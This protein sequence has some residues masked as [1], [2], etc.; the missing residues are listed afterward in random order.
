ML[1]WEFMNL[2]IDMFL[3]KEIEDYI[4]LYFNYNSVNDNLFES[5]VD[6][7]STLLIALDIENNFDIEL[8]AENDFSASQSINDFI[9]I[10]ES[11][12]R[13]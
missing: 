11:K 7:Y 8:S 1:I 3:R 12:I 13:Q 4:K 5:S 2:E 10:I 9:D 6:F